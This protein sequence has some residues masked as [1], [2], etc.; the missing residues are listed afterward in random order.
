MGL[1]FFGSLIIGGLAG[2]IASNL[3]KAGTGIFGNILLGIGGAFVP[4]LLL[5]LLGIYAA[6]A[7]VPQLIVGIAGACGLIWLVRRIRG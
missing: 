2:W 1:G 6:S 3:M 4:N 5:Q 7:V